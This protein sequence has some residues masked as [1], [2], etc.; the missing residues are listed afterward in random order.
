MTHTRS[1][2]FAAWLPFAHTLADTAR[3]LFAPNI[4][5]APGVVV[6]ADRSLV[7]ALDQAIETR[8]CGL[9]ENAYPDH[10]IYGEEHGAVRLDAE[11]VWVLDPI[12]GTAAF[13]AGVP[14][15][16][17][18][19]AL[20]YRGTPVLGLIDLPVT[21]DRWIGVAG[22]PTRHGDQTCRTRVCARLADALLTT[23]NPDLYDARERPV[24]DAL[25][26]DT[27]WRIYG[28][29]CM[30]YGLLASGRT[31][32]AIDTGLKFWD[33]APYVPIIEGA[34]G[35]ITD[36]EGRPLRLQDWGARV[37]AAGDPARHRDA[38]ARMRQTLS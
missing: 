20:L 29:S 9:I 34:G 32:I 10:G 25:R 12:D 5:F 21:Q 35:V 7:T 22:R 3:A 19:I 28:A 18:L 17:T 38:L 15:F 4:A 27:R 30:A 6:K 37:L 16:G 24:L 36:W 14:V 2:T 13:I 11:Y 8:L 31:D 23:S 26:A 33:Y 1:D